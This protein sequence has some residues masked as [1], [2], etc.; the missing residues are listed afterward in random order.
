LENTPP[1]YLFLGSHARECYS[2]DTFCLGLSYFH[3]LAGQEP[4]EEHLKGVHCPELLQLKLQKLWRTSSRSSQY[5]VIAEVMESLDAPNDSSEE[6][7]NIKNVLYDTFY[8]YL[9]LFDLD[10]SA[11][12]SDDQDS[13]EGECEYPY[14]PTNSVLRETIDCLGLDSGGRIV[15]KAKR[16]CMDQFSEDRAEWSLHF[17]TNAVMKRVRDNLTLLGDGSLDLLC[18]M[19][20][21]DASK[22]CSLHEALTSSLFSPMRVE[23]PSLSST[24]GGGGGG[25][26]GGRGRSFMHYKNKQ[27]LPIF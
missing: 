10:I 3:L 11:I 20:N 25:G 19:V 8:R 18:L 17:G 12:T 1:E 26:G 23:D 2:A 4:Y 21:L 15:T 9:V 16:E 5:R 13:T 22:R 6:S 14:P 27:F 24:T 7:K